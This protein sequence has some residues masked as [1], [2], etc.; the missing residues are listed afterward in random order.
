M[1]GLHFALVVVTSLTP[2]AATPYRVDLNDVLIW[3]PADYPYPAPVIQ[4]VGDPERAHIVFGSCRESTP[5]A[6]G[7][8]EPDALDAYAIRLKETDAPIPDLLMLIGD[9]I[10][11]DVTSKS[12]RMWLRKRRRRRHRDAPPKQVVDFAEYARLYRESWT[13]RTCAG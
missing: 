11:A 7:R 13:T 12:T 3:P 8:K 10:Y 1:S 2:A 6:E 9:Q 4:T 5:Y